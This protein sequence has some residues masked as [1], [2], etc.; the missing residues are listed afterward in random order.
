M[1]LLAS[2]RLG[3][4]TVV[5][6]AA[7]VVLAACGSSGG[8]SSDNGGSGKS[9][10]VENSFDVTTAD[11][12]RVY[13]ITGGM[14]VHQVYQPLLTF[15][16]SDVSKPVPLIA[17]SYSLSS[18]GKTLT[19]PLRT[20]VKFSDGTALTAQDVVFTFNRVKNL[21]GSP[22]FL[23]ADVTASAPDDHTVVL[24][25][26]EPNAALPYLITNPALGIENMKVFKEHGATD[27]ANASK[28]D[29]AQ[30]WL[31]AHSAG[32]GPYELQSFSTTSQITLVANPDYWGP[33]KPTYTKVVVR[34]VTADVQKLD[35]E[36]GEAQMALDLS[37]QQ[38]TGMPGNLVVNH[39]PTSN[40]FFVFTNDNPAISKFTSDP[41]FQAA[42]RDGLDYSALV[43]LAGTGAVQAP[44]IIPTIFAG[45]LPAADAPKTDLSAAKAALAKSDYHG[46]QIQMEFPS[47]LTKNGVAFTTLAQAV[48]AQLKQVGINI[49]L[50]PAPLATSLPR[51]RDGK[52]QLG[53]WLWGADFPD[54]SDYLQFLPGE[55]VGLR[56]GWAK[57]SDDALTALNT[58]AATTTNLDSRT[59]LF[60]QI[61]QKMNQSGPFMPLFQSAQVTVLADSVHGYKYN[62]AWTVEFADLS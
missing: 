41:N 61:Q 2:E 7:A 44:G 4:V 43:K 20:D 17:K 30:Q 57:G 37:P 60:Q 9:L 53:L 31:D 32:S 27:D 13:E 11:P 59:Q 21:Q 54:P 45:A 19:L 15:N 18:D 1:K 35:V 16:G 25:S 62:S 51:Y 5:A 14:I 38:A 24:K 29:K 50:A 6:C 26:K 3:V 55:T 47:D 49:Q 10:V 42:V 58:Q 28:T 34:N 56:A 52:E 33:K 12:G 40:T 46:E 23:V 39:A 36:K 48:Q 8:G 22:A